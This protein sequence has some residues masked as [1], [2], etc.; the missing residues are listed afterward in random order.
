VNTTTE[1]VDRSSEP[2]LRQGVLKDAALLLLSPVWLIIGIFILGIPAVLALGWAAGA[3]MLWLSG[4]WSHG[5][6]LIGTL[7]S[8]ASFV[9]I[10][11]M[12][13]NVS[14]ETTADS[15]LAWLVFVFLVLLYMAPATVS[16]FY[17][18]RTMRLRWAGVDTRN[19]A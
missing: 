5:H 14:P 19:T 10:A 17:L 6:K 4:C 8:A 18:W 13:F 15:V 2:T 3:I 16:V 12:S 7:L 11:T 9:G 1:D